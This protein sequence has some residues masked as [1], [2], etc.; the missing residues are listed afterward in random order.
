MSMTEKP[1]VGC[2]AGIA[3]QCVDFVQLLTNNVQV[4]DAFK[5]QKFPFLGYKSHFCP[6]QYGNSRRSTG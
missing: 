4:N 6:R 1:D 2:G 3:G 5:G